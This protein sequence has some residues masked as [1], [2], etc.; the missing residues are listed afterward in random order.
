ME[1]EST[2][3][4]IIPSYNSALTLPGTLRSILKQKSDHIREVIVVDSSDDRAM[5]QV[6]ET[7]RALGVKFI[8]AGTRVIAAIQRNIGAERAKGSLLMFLDADVL[9]RPDYVSMIV[10][11]RQAGIRAGFGSVALPRVQRNSLVAAAQYYAQLSEYL[12]CG[13]RRRKGLILGCNNFCDRDLFSFSGG[14]PPMRM[15]ED[16]V[17]GHNLGKLTSIWFVP[18]ATVEHVF[19]QSLTEFFRYQQLLGQWAVRYRRAR[20]DGGDKF[21]TSAS[22]KLSRVLPLVF[23]PAYFVTKIL[24]IVPRVFAAGVPHVVRFIAVL[25]LFV[26]GIVYWTKGFVR[27]AQSMPGP[28]NWNCNSQQNGLF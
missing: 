2:V 19:R 18:E 15:S 23:G 3:S 22:G 5:A 27:E 24:R 9:L 14:F 26:V 7:Y 11:A 12:P 6:E 21:A 8:H 13:A 1:S 17:Y 28:V 16:A 20:N 10:S 4:I 25:P